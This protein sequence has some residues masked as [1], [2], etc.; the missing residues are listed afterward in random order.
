MLHK[1]ICGK[2]FKY[3]FAY[4]SYMKNEVESCTREH[5]CFREH[6]IS[7]RNR[8]LKKRLGL[9]CLTVHT[10]HIHLS[11]YSYLCS[12]GVSHM[13]DLHVSVLRYIEMIQ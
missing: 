7:F 8:M 12:F 6:E 10:L 2:L 1:T 5:H 13:Y 9:V 11:T 4:R 3:F